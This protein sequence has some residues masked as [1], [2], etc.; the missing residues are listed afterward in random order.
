MG[1]DALLGA[2]RSR[3]G[4]VLDEAS[5]AGALHECGGQEALHRNRTEKN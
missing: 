2:E 5:Q 3:F 1:C 4:L